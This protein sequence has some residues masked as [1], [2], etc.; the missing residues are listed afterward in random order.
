MP[1]VLPRVGGEVGEAG[2]DDLVSGGMP[3][4]IARRGVGSAIEASFQAVSSP[5]EP[6][7]EVQILVGAFVVCCVAQGEIYLLSQ[8]GDFCEVG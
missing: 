2:S 1:L 4:R 6:M 8:L 5:P 3:A 7:P